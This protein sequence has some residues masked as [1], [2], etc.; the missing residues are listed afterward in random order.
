[1]EDQYFRACNGETHRCAQKLNA[2][3]N[4][5]NSTTDANLNAAP[6][7]LGGADNGCNWRCGKLHRRS[8]AVHK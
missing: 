8:T 6:V 7:C 3:L 4:S 1:M 5:G 2:K